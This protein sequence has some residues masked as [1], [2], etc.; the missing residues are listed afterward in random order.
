M[1]SKYIASMRSMHHHFVRESSAADDDAATKDSTFAPSS[2]PISE[3][4]SSSDGDIYGLLLISLPSS[5]DWEGLA[6]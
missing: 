4:E 3:L 6:T 5:L 2:E 1:P